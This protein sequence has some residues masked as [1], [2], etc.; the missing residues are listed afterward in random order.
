MIEVRNTFIHIDGGS[1]DERIV[2][3]MPHSMFRQCL[4]EEQQAAAG[5]EPVTSTPAT[6]P[7]STNGIVAAGRH[8]LAPGTEVMVQGLVK[9][10][11]FNG[12]CG[13]VQSWDQERERYNILLSMPSAESGYQQAK[14]KP[15]NMLL[16]IPG[17]SFS[18]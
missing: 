17:G 1:A 6:L 18:G 7:R 4:F 15:E 8:L 10:P 11:A 9:A 2:Q 5:C 16:T 3:S 12:R 14:V 13:V